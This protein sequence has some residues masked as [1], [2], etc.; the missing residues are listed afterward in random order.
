MARAKT[1]PH[2]PTVAWRVLLVM[3]LG[4]TWMSVTPR[5]GMSASDQSVV[6]NFTLASS[7]I[8]LGEPARV[9]FVVE[10]TRIDSVRF[11][12]GFNRLANFDV[13]IV[14]PDGS[15]ARISTIPTMGLG[16]TGQIVVEP[17]GSYAQS[18][19][20][21]RWYAFEQSGRHEIRIALKNPIAASSADEVVATPKETLILVVGPRD[22]ERLMELCD[23]LTKEVLAAPSVDQASEFVDS[24]SFIQDPIAVPSLEK[25][26]R[27]DSFH[28]TAV[29]SALAR[30]GDPDALAALIRAFNSGDAERKAI[31]RE[32][33]AGLEGETPDDDSTP[34]IR[35][36][37]RTSID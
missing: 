17:E 26:L 33:V 10:N 25:I 27:R 23:D 36:V 18:I 35:A 20:I 22:P 1:I 21:N 8:T 9:Q 19:L 34:R 11:D 31:I 37:P 24:L 6:A 5:A 16:L 30:I 2:R 32:H 28:D 29:V 13:S 3:S 4:L 14:K 15:S 12:T 7:H